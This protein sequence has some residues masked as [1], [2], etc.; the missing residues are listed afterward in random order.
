VDNGSFLERYLNIITLNV[1]FPPDYGGMIDSWFRI[2]S[3]KEAGVKIQLH[4]F[5]HGRPNSVELESACESVCYY[6]RSRSFIRFLSHKPFIVNTRRSGKLLKNLLKNDYPILFDGLHTCFVLDDP[7]LS[8]RKK[9]VRLHNIEHRYYRS[10][11]DHEAGYLKKIYFRVEAGRLEKFEKILSLA[12]KVFPISEADLEYFT[13]GYNNPIMLPPFHPFEKAEIKTGT[14]NFILYHGD[15]SVNVNEKVALMLTEKVFRKVDFQCIIAGRQPSG[16]L[17]RAVSQSGNT[18]LVENPDESQMLELIRDAQVNVVPMQDHQGFK[19]KLL[20]ALFAGRH[21]ITGTEAIKGFVNGSNLTLGFRDTVT[22]A[23]TP[24][25]FLDKINSL[26]NVSFSEE[27]ISKR[28][29]L[30]EEVFNNKMNAAVLAGHIFDPVS[31][32]T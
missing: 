11:A 27:D 28:I 8:G 10:L 31:N 20:F 14:G 15:L 1:P 24:G 12:D 19:I 3:L 25:E 32:L 2:K 17:R 22:T 23:D 13:G 18:R 26:I 4:C 6:R 7:G 29:K 16:R 9:F 30:L 21:C 5:T